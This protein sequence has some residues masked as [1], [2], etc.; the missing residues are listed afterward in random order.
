MKT[1]NE[2]KKENQDAG[3]ALMIAMIQASQR[4]VKK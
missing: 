2:E 1:I 3:V 4:L